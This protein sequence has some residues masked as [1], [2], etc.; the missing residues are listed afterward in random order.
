[1]AEGNLYDFFD[2]G[3]KDKMA[4]KTADI[5]VT[6][7]ELIN[8]VLDI[9]NPTAAQ[10]GFTPIKLYNRNKLLDEAELHKAFVLYNE[11]YIKNRQPPAELRSPVTGIALVPEAYRTL[12]V[13]TKM[14]DNDPFIPSVYNPSANDSLDKLPQVGRTTQQTLEN[15]RKYAAT[16]MRFWMPEDEPLTFANVRRIPTKD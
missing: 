2:R 1:M 14:R 10:Y 7:E 13:K 3:L 15:I 9:Y 5:A 12:T 16:Q 8:W 4:A 11:Y 6:R